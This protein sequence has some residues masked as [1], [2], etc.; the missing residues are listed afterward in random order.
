MCVYVYVYADALSRFFLSFFF[1]CENLMQVTDVI[2]GAL[3]G[4]FLVAP[5]SVALH[6]YLRL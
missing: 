6:S 5:L 2:A 4:R 1:F 3:V